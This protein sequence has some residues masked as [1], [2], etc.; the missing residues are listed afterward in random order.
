MLLLALTL[1]SCDRFEHDFTAQD[2]VDIHE[3]FF[4]PLG[5]ALATISASDMSAIEAIYR[6]D[7]LHNGVS[8]SE[9]I[10]WMQS[11]L[12]QD[13]DA[14]FSVSDQHYEKID[15]NNALVNWHLTISSGGKEILADS[16]FVGERVIRQGKP[17]LLYGNQTCVQET[18]QQLVIAQYFTFRTCPNCPPAEAELYMLQ[19]Q[20]PDNFIYLEHHTMMELMVPGDDTHQY[21]GAYSSPNTVFQ[22]MEKVSGGAAGN[23]ALYQPIVE[24]LLATDEPISYEITDLTYADKSVS[25]M[26]HMQPRLDIPRE[27]LVLNY[28]IITD[29]VDYVNAV[30]DP[31]HNVVRAV[32]SISLAESD[33]EAGI[34]IQLTGHE[35]LPQDFKLVV[36]AQN[37][38]QPFENNSTIYGGIVK[39]VS[40]SK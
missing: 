4:L 12:N 39:S 24:N 33:L 31:L 19:Q 23:V 28:V 29:E 5:A 22:G 7:Y 27:N 37:K 34:P 1:M 17:W 2:A 32:G 8:K 13:P 21:Y 38:P 35:S 6:D 20:Y 30:G 26:V 14:V 40:R 18:D 3:N 16:L 10:T 15:D 25:A 9:R 11:F 36:F